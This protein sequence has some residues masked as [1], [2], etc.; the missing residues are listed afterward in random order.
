[1]NVDKF[2]QHHGVT[3]NPFLAEEARHDPVFDRLVSQDEQSHP[4]FAK[5]LGRIDRPSSAVVFGEKGSGKTAI[6]LLM[7]LQVQRHNRDSAE[8]RTLLVAYDDLNP[9]LDEIVARAK[10]H[11]DSSVT[12]LDHVRLADHQDAILARAVTKLVS[13]LAGGDDSEPIPLPEDVNKRIKD[14]P[15]RQRID[16]AI[17]A[18]L[19]DQPFSGN[20]RQRW[21]KLCSRLKLGWK[22]SISMLRLWA[23]VCTLAAFGLLGTQ[24]LLPL[25]AKSQTLP[26]WVMPAAG[27]ATGGAIILWILW[28][29]RHMLL[30]RHCRRLNKEMPAIK[31]TA[32]QLRQMLLSLR[33][34]DLGDQP[35]PGYHGSED[36]DSR[37]QLTGKLLELLR[38]FDYVGIMILVDRVDEPTIVAGQ[39]DRMKAVVWPMLDNKFLQQDGVGRVTFSRKPGWTSRA[40]WIR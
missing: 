10:R 1:M 6:R 20:V 3:E 7:D 5:I 22:P 29:I 37:Y 15:R 27:I 23:V 30:W 14:M 38:V 25:I 12:V 18:A 34:G 8:R 2:F 32:M 16:L 4:D 40:W 21:S 39:P 9:V 36:T 31:R 17:L 35:W 28:S 33:T 13:A 24:R 11:S 26:M 19:Y